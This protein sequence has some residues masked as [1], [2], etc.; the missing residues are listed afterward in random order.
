MVDYLTP[1]ENIVKIIK[2]IDYLN[3]ISTNFEKKIDLKINQLYKLY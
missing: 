2:S 3:S 1:S